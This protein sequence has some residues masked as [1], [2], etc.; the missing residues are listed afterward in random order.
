M[1]FLSRLTQWPVDTVAAAIVTADSTVDTVGDT[2]QVF[3]VASVTKLVAAYGVMLAVE[4]GALALDDAAGPAG[5]TIRHLL[6]HASGVAFDSRESQK[7][8]GERRIYSSAGYD[9][10]AD[11]VAEATGFSFPDY[12]REGVFEP[13][14]M[15]HTTL[16]GS[17]GHGLRSN[18]EDLGAFAREVL[19][20]K[21][22]DPSTVREMRSVQFP[23]LRGVVPG[24][25]MQKP[26]PWGLGFELRGNK[27]PHWTG[28]SMPAETAGHFGMSGT[29]LWV[30][31]GYA[32][33]ALTDR[34]FGDW[35]KPLWAETNEAVWTELN[36]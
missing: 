30:A 9:W 32:M 5:S 26:C 36:F 33:V 6:T 2:R 19:S 7:P 3:P 10:A 35:A 17:A 11:A 31:E 24:Y 15:A 1:S 27:N 29:Y 4:E 22:L 16:E 21:L 18:V 12:L 20:P 34:D 28:A 25:G 8:V 23:E 14:G 13:L